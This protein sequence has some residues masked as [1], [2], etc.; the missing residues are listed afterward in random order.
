MGGMVRF[1][2]ALASTG[3]GFGDIG[4]RPCGTGLGHGNGIGL[5]RLEGEL[6]EGFSI[7]FTTQTLFYDYD[8][9]SK[10]SY[11]VPAQTLDHSIA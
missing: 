7:T 4:L 5:L 6:W 10:V 11:P 2:G 1:F 3:H 8:L 9:D